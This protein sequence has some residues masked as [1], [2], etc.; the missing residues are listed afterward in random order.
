MAES[1]GRDHAGKRS[2]PIP[3]WNGLFDHRRKIATAVWVFLWCIDR[4]TK[5]DSGIGFVLGGSI[6]AASRIA[7]EL[8]DSERTVR[9]HLERLAVNRYIALKRFPYGFVI[10]VMNSCKFDVWRSDKS[11]HPEWTKVPARSDKSAGQ[12]GQK[13]RSDDKNCP[14]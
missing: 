11:G 4:V 13:C 3:V 10:T 2:Y 14:V 6:I 5:E 8:D 1:F 7:D 12:I 9:R